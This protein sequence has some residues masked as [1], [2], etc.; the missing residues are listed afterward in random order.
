[1][2]WED[3]RN[4]DVESAVFAEALFDLSGFV[5]VGTVRKDGSPRISPVE[6]VITNG[7]LYLGIT[8]GSLKGKDLLRDPRCTIHSSIK[9]RKAS[10]GEFKL[11][12]RAVE[13]NDDKERQQYCEVLS[14]KIGWNPLDYDYKFHLFWID[15]ESAGLFITKEKVRIF[16]RFRREERMKEFRQ[17][18]EGHKKEGAV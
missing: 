2:N 8:P 6:P 5:F 17:N 7:K 10:E 13:V 14:R 4:K 16:R 9:D 1:M 15:I 11:H 12:G 18:I 3:F